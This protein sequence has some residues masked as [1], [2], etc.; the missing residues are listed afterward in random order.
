MNQTKPKNRPLRCI[1]SWIKTGFSWLFSGII[2]IQ[3][4]K[5]T[6]V[7]ERIVEQ[8][9]RHCGNEGTTAGKS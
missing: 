6:Q 3:A 8:H 7:E 4:Y 9:L 1:V 5:E 2:F